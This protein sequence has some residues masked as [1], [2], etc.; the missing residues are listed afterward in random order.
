M[1]ECAVVVVVM[2]RHCLQYAPLITPA[3]RPL[4]HHTPL[5]LLPRHIQQFQIVRL[6]PHIVFYQIPVNAIAVTRL[7]VVVRDVFPWRH[8]AI[9]YMVGKRNI[10][11]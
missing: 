2:E 7:T 6:I 3:V 11:I 5:T 4:I 9:I 1:A 8:I 10:V